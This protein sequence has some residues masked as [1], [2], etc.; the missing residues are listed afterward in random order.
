MTNKLY[1]ILIGILIL[2]GTRFIFCYRI[3]PFPNSGNLKYKEGEVIY[4][5][6]FPFINPFRKEIILNKIITYF[7]SDSFLVEKESNELKYFKEQ[8]LTHKLEILSIKTD[9]NN[10]L[11]LVSSKDNSEAEFVFILDQKTDIIIGHK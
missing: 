5:P 4:F 3:I 10:Y 1:I 9:N 2:L 7:S 6:H 11:I 8:A